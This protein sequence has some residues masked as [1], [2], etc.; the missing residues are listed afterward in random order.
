MSTAFALDPFQA[1]AVA[2][3]DRGESVLVAAPTGAGKTVVAEHAAARVLEQDSGR[4]F[5]TTPIKA[6][7]NQKY[8]D[9]AR[10]HGSG[11]VGLLT[12]DNSINGDARVVVMTTEVLR[13]MIYAGRDLSDL[14]FVV[15]DEVHYLQDAYRGPV[16]EEVIIHLPTHVRLVCLSATV[17]NAD[18]LAAWLTEVR[19]ETATIIEHQRPVELEHLYAVSDRVEERLRV[20]PTLVHDRP[21]PDG[22]EFDATRLRGRPSGRQTRYRWFTPDRVE[23]VEHLA[24]ED[25]LPAIFFVFSRAGCDE[26][27]R[28]LARAGPPLTT[29]EE[30]AWIT[31]IVER[32][33][34]GLSD[35]DLAALQYGIWLDGIQ[36][37]IAAHH[38]G[39]VPPFKEA[40]E[41]C[42]VE[43]LVKVVFA[44]E[45]LALGINMPARS[46]VISSLSKFTGERHERLTPSQYT[47]LTG[48]AGRRGIDDHGTAV[49][50]WSPYV[51]FADVATL[52]G[53]RQF[54]LRSS[55]RPTYNMAAN[56]VRRHDAEAAHRLLALSFAQFQADRVVVVTERRMEDRRR[57]LV[58]AEAAATCELGDVDEWVELVET[59]RQR[60]RPSP[61]RVIE[62]ELSG[63]RPGDVVDAP[64][65]GGHERV[66]VL[67]VAHRAQGNVRVRGVT[68]TGRVISFGTMTL[69]DAPTRVGEVELPEP[70]R[71]NNQKFRREV[72]RRLERARAR[73]PSRSARSAPAVPDDHPVAA[74]PDAT[75]HLRA[76]RRAHRLR[77]E[78]E[79]HERRMG[80]EQGSLA[81]EFDRVLQVLDG[82][83]YLD[84]WALTD[85][86][87]RLARLYHES[88]LL[89]SEAL[90]AGLLDGLDAPGLVAMLSCFTYEH[91]SP[92]PAPPPSFP[93]VTLR[94]RWERLA[95][96]AAELVQEEESLALRLTREPDPGFVPLAYEWTAGDQLDE[97]LTE[98]DLSGGDFVRQMRQLLDLLRQIAEVAPDPATA[99]TA[100]DAVHLVDRG[101]VA[102]SSAVS[103]PA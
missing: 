4:L 89:V 85:D 79:A 70:Y 29:A 19:G 16:W 72:A 38:A 51:T 47:Q 45:T 15:L 52:A 78:L 96:L 54:E 24:T 87:L 57:Q 60:A 36:A 67:S 18:E 39:M 81:R 71:P 102:A 13:N 21:N 94:G 11:S 97:V 12:G 10:R 69:S 62:E 77:R 28:T 101:V 32:H 76:A 84:G 92:E 33:V 14:R 59:E 93:T 5:Y 20:I 100:R 86:G 37:G 17:S 26:A 90:V 31:D 88:D 68:R 9:L 98:D 27:A 34:A 6:L 23:M 44:T 8:G 35:R 63:L 61:Q 46:V 58:E 64:L 41:A 30:R 65:Q 3:V 43:G 82:R 48:R 73:R 91:R 25:L 1:Q 2:A 40:V 50:L 7:S 53:S 103:L 75:K 42:F 49:V 66:A 56:L 83:G 74:C 95:D 99:R 22:P 55:F 80:R